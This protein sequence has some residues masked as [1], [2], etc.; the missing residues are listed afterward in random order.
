MR[1]AQFGVSS[2]LLTI[3]FGAALAN[4]LRGTPTISRCETSMPGEG[5]I[6]DLHNLHQIRRAHEAVEGLWRTTD[7]N[8]DRS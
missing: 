4:V 3:F 2:A 6:S 7:R 1:D 8:A 5:Q